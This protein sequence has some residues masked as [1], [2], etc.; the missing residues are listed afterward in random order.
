MMVM[1]AMVMMEMMAIMVMIVM[2][3]MLMMTVM[4]VMIAM[5]VMSRSRTDLS[6]TLIPVRKTA[7]T[8]LWSLRGEG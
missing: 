6:I 4:T 7:D 3:A 5:T 2:M 8:G 1:R